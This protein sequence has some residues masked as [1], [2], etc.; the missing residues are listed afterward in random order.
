LKIIPVILSGGSGTRLWPLSRAAFPKQF[1]PLVSSNSM[2]QETL[3]RLSGWATIDSPV[4]VCGNEHRFLVAEQLRELN[5]TPKSIILEPI[6]RNT[7]PAIAVAA[8]ALAAEHDALMLVLPSDHVISN[9][10]A[11]ENAVTQAS[12]AAEAGQLVTFGILPNHPETGY[13]YIQSGAAI[14]NV[15]GCFSVS[16]FVEKPDLKTAE[17][18]LES[19]DF[20]W[21][22]G[23]FLFKPSVY[24]AELEKYEPRILK[25]AT[26]A[27]E[28]SYQDLDFCR[29]DEEAFSESPSDSIDYAVMEQTELAAVVPVDMGWNDVGSW[30][31]LWDVQSKD[32]NGNALRGDVIVDQVQNSLIRAESRVVAAIGVKDLIIVETS[33]AVLVAHKDSSQDV[34]KVVDYLKRHERSEHQTHTRVYRPWGWYES[35]DLGERFQVKRIMVKPG[36]KLSLQLH[37]QRAE[38]WVVVRGSALVTRNHKVEVLT[39]NQSTYIPIGVQ[40]RLENPGSEPLHLIEVQSG[41]YLGEDDIVRFEDS[42]G[43]S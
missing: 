27:F 4:V 30:T 41:S 17:S 39:E 6:G 9:L 22:S 8:L 35:I 19:G 43:R 24:L 28:N 11:F 7:A 21:N 31:A 25:H 32:Q 15:E 26:L 12:V 1:L 34:K 33:D 38:H 10:V 3:K 37:K 2:L 36:G 18:Y 13:G 23:M 29:L 14:E 5:I 16:R 20:F 40:H 42:Y